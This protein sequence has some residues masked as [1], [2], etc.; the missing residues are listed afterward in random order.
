MPTKGWYG[1]MHPRLVDVARLAATQH[2]VVS[3]AQAEALGVERRVMARAV[4]AGLAER[5]H[6]Q[7]VAFEGSPASPLR[8]IH[9]AV[10]QVPN[11]AASHE[12]SMI[13]RGLD[14][15]PFEVAVVGPKGSPNHYPGIRVHRFADLLDHH[16]EFIDGIRCTTIERT[17]VDLGSRF[18]GPRLHLLLDRV[19]IQERL[20][21]VA[22]I[23]RTLREVHHQ[24]RRR[25]GTLTRLIDQRRPSDPTPRS[26]L[27]TH[28][29]ALV[30]AS[31][32]PTPLKELPLPSLSIT[33]TVDRAWVEA[34]LIFEIDGRTWH[35][36]EQAMAKDRARDRAAAAEGWQVCRVLDEELD[37][38]GTQMVMD[39]LLVIYRRR[40]S[41][42]RQ[43]S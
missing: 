2:G 38:P 23:S 13:A 14:R 29:D 4:S 30:E 41:D 35:A 7:V 25:I 12:S 6:P 19:V 22:A 10:L 37:G 33:G 34:K 8:D 11:A 15:I 21:T 40:L 28:A 26:T 24:G 32:L 18:S 42:L 1:S 31:E 27:E 3:L 17:I 36:R 5:I 16:I 9:A 43:A 20:T 39:E